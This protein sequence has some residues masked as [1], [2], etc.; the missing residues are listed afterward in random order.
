MKMQRGEDMGDMGRL[1]VHVDFLLMN[2]TPQRC[3]PIMGV[4]TVYINDS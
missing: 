2:K 3:G 4:S 1:H